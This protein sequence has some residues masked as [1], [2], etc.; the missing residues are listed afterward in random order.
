MDPRSRP[1]VPA[2]SVAPVV[3]GA[4]LLGACGV[5]A[6]VDPADGPTLC[7]FKLATGLDCPGCGATRA[8]HALLRGDLLGAADHNVLALVAFP[9]VA[10][11]LF[12]WMTRAFRG[13]RVA[14]FVPSPVLTVVAAVVVLGFWV[15]R[16]LSAAP[17]DWLASGT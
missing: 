17:F 12:T 15:V 11:G 4:A 14:T 10:W 7:P 6:I 9:L 8:A 16:N 1:T 3:A 2:S 13:P 5:L